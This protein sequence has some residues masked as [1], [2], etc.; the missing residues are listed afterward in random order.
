MR[1]GT[2]F[3]TKIFLCMLFAIMAALSLPAL[4]ARLYLDDQLLADAQQ[5]ALRE[6]RL[7]AALLTEYA[8]GPNIERRVKNLGSVDVRV[9]L[10]DKQGQVLADSSR[11][12]ESLTDLDN[13]ADR[14]EVQDALTGG[15]G[16]S[17]RFSNTLQSN[18]I[19]AAIR[20]D[21]GNIVRIAVPYAAL[22]ARLHKQFNRLGLVGGTAVFLALLLAYFLSHRLKC[23]LSHM[24]NV[25]E[26]ISLGK[27]RRRLHTVP[28][29]EFTALAD[30]VNRMAENI[31]VHI[32]TVADQKGQLASILETMH[33]GVLVLDSKGRIR[34]CNRAL[35][36]IFPAA[37]ESLG[38]AVVEVIP[39][40]ALQEAVEKLLHSPQEASQSEA[41]GEAEPG[42]SPEYTPRP[43]SQS[44][45]V[46]LAQGR[47]LNVHLTRPLMPTPNLGAVAVFHDISDLVRLERIRRDFVTNVSHELRTPLTAIQGYAETLLHLDD[48]PADAQRFSEIIY[49][50]GSYLGRMVEELLSL[51]RLENGSEPCK[52]RPTNLHDCVQAGI[53][54]CLHA[55]QDKQLQVQ[56]DMPEQLTVMGNHTHLIQVM[57]NLLENACRYAPPASSITVSGTAQQ[58]N[59]QLLVCDQGPGIPAHELSRIF[60]RFYRVDK[61]RTSPQNN[62]ATMPNSGGGKSSAGSTG[63]GLAICK[64]IVER[65]HGHIWAESPSQQAPTCFTVLLPLA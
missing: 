23:S 52:L 21:N 3:R 1:T 18:T 51:A 16:L 4:Y 7:T 22:E 25:V 13:H 30:A 32:S 48:L 9:T 63:L 43:V 33:E 57:R 5:Q 35:T 14:P 40:P 45:Q 47:I 10:M 53:A 19:Y 60:E 55:L 11:Q 26:A 42:A 28:G 27:Y 65:H 44:L 15:N 61:Q 50:H 64:H 37:Q 38:G 59:A 20:T 62:A 29:K 8:K 31:D 39:V 17:T 58:Q 6:A 54:L 24:V 36:D 49:K 56:V 41:Q 46:E 2:S 34:S 12:V